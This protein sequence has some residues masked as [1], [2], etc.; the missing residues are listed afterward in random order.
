MGDRKWL[1]SHLERCLQDVWDV[2]RVSV[3][4]DGDYLFRGT[5][6]AGFVR[7]E[8]VKPPMV[9]VFA[10]AARDV[11]RSAKLLGEL[12]DVNSRSRFSWAS[13]TG[14][15]VVVEQAIHV[16]A[17]TRGSLRHALNAV[18]STADDVGPMIAAVFGGETPLIPGEA[19][20]AEGI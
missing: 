17:L 18:T 16:S 12:N 1:R 5:T 20:L 2:C 10:I 6:C 15:T 3:D 4:E 14:G 19:T 13:W 7:I 9:R 11:P 8:A